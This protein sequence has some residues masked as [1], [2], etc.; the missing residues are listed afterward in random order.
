LLSEIFAVLTDGFHK[1]GFKLHALLLQNLF[2]VADSPERLTASLCPPEKQ[3]Q[4]SSNAHFIKDHVATLLAGSF[5]NMSAG[6]VERFAS[7]MMEYKSDLVQFKN[8]LRDFLVASKQ[9]STADFAEEEKARLAEVAKERLAAVP[10]MIAPNE[11]N[12]DDDED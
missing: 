11:L 9:F 4:Y 7:G 3:G 12:M 6:D 5:P 8:H 10:G 2:T 1:P